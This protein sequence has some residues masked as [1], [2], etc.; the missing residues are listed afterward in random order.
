MRAYTEDVDN[1]SLLNYGYDAIGNLVRDDAENIQEIKWN[2]YGKIS[3]ITRTG[4]NNK[5]NIEFGYDASGQR[6]WKTVKPRV[7][8]VQS[9][10][11]DWITTLYIR[12][13][14]CN[15]I[16]TYN[17]KYKEQAG[18]GGNTE[19]V[20]EIILIEQAIFA[21]NRIGVIAPKKVIAQETNIMISSGGLYDVQGKASLGAVTSSTSATVNTT[22][23][24]FYLGR[25]NYELSNH[26]GNVLAVVS[27]RKQMIDDGTYVNGLKAISVLDN[28]SDYYQAEYQSFGMY[29]AFGAPLTG[30]GYVKLNSPMY[31]YGFNGQEK[32]DEVAG[33]GNSNTAE[34]WQ[35]DTRLGRR[36]NVDP[37][38]YPWHGSYTCF[39]SNPIN[40]ND[41]L[42]LYSR[43]GQAE[44]AKRRADRNGY[45]TTDIS[46]NEKTKEYEFQ[47]RK[48]EDGKVS[49]YRYESEAKRFGKKYDESKKWGYGKFGNVEFIGLEESTT[50]HNTS[51][52]W[53][54]PVSKGNVLLGSMA[55]SIDF[56]G[57]IKNVELYNQGF[58]KG[59][60]ANY[61][62][63]GRNA[64]LFKNA[65]MTNYVMPISFLSKT[66][67]VLGKLSLGIGIGTDIIGL[68]IYYENGPNA[69][70]AVSPYKF[71]L[72][73]SMSFIGIKNP[74]VATLYFGVDNFYPGG[75][76]GNSDHAGA[77]ADQ[78]K[79]IEKN[80]KV[81]SDFNL[82]RDI[83]GG[84]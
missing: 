19:F 20:D 79:L 66:G 72:N 73:T 76:A 12:D 69:L 58:R 63:I 78:S 13:A 8:G 7:N 25:K 29:Y 14:S 36:F 49:T 18:S 1:Q 16:A 42:G 21:A 9:I 67:G 83:P 53:Y 27:D 47:L 45:E 54:N 62:L 31:R 61:Q 74:I 23:M 55:S 70:N 41:P 81:V 50:Q 26:L 10:Q 11:K 39:N 65:P 56:L 46:F 28:I 22:R 34:Y 43:V 2:A 6:L 5:S 57:K 40:F 15:P 24:D 82:Y 3:S 32:D 48:R 71:T 84:Y 80:Q 59:V 38:T 30:R 35:Y 33:V 4:N 51:I 17:E 60:S 37:I 64:N 75:W 52:D 68:G 77:I 44:R